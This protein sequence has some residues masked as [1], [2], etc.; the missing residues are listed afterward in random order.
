[1]QKVS[2]IKIFTQSLLVHR[3]PWR[4]ESTRVSDMELLAKT[5]N[6]FRPLTTFAESSVLD[7]WL[8]SGYAFGGVLED[9]LSG[10][11]GTSFLLSTLSM[12][13]TAFFAL[14]GKLTLHYRAPISQLHFQVTA[15]L[16]SSLSNH[17]RF[18]EPAI[19]RMAF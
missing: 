10:I 15:F 8:G 6:G 7:V 1:M 16:S 12:K 18:W 3:Q 4:S 19:S 14:L 9:R 2:G 17:R 5:V 13:G 11:I